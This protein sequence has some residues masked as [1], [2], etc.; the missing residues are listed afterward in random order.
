M[1]DSR[2]LETAI[3]LVFLFL[4]VSLMT[5]AIQEIIASVTKLR[6]STLQAGLKSM[7]VQGQQGLV[8]YRDLITHP[9]VAPIKGAPSYISAPQFSAAVV[10]LLGPGEGMPTAVASLRIAAQN[11]PPS[12]IKPVILAAFREGETDLGKFELRLQ[13]WFND[14]MDR[15]SGV[16]K[17]L[18]QYISFGIGAVIAVLFQLDAIGIA[19]RLWNEPATRDA[20]L[21]NAAKAVGNGNAASQLLARDFTPYHVTPIWD[22][23]LAQIHATSVIGWIATAIAISLGAPFWFD[24]LQ[25]LVRV[26]STG[27]VPADTAS[28]DPATLR[29]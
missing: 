18:S 20:A 16:Y 8:F 13:A 26:R 24:L 27:P 7:L 23:V 25:S 28:I 17:R 9:L 1:F 11:L 14:A 22:S 6:A 5:M 2:V 4:G 10:Q 12:P 29:D 21:A 19:D 15:L 3:G